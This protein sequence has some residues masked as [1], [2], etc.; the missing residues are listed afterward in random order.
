MLLISSSISMNGLRPTEG[1]GKGLNRRMRLKCGPA[2][3]LIELLVVIAVIAILAAM[4]LPALNRSKIAANSTICR[5]NLRQWGFVL[6]QY[7]DDSRAYPPGFIWNGTNSLGGPNNPP[8]LFW[9]DWLEQYSHTRWSTWTWDMPGPPPRG[10]QVCPD[11]SRLRGIIGDW[12]YGAY[13]YND[14]GATWND[15]KHAGFGLCVY[16]WSPTNF[17]VSPNANPRLLRENDVQVPA[18]MIALADAPLMYNA[19]D[20]AK[21]DCFAWPIL[22]QP[23]GGVIAEFG[24]GPQAMSHNDWLWMKKRHGGC[25]NVSFCDGHAENL[26]W[27]QLWD[28]R[29]P[30][31]AQRWNRDHQPH[32][33]IAPF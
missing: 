32:P 3:T 4:L 33:E 19:G 16:E 30:A 8:F 24:I 2:F 20:K 22:S 13:G 10:I 28:W 5:S 23:S 21:G 15:G 1:K 12:G 29:K 27:A 31:V 14:R 25:W 6:R 26:K 9:A 7:L 18:D 17:P 11:Y